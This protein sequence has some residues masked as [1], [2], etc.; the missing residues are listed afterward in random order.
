MQRHNLWDMATCKV[1]MNQRN[2]M[3]KESCPLGVVIFGVDNM[4]LVTVCPGAAIP[5]WAWR[6]ADTTKSRGDGVE[7]G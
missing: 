5:I 6:G 3:Q 4:T 1:P 2:D 7:E